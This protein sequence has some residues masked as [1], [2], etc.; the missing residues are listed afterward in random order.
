M[1]EEL[2]TLIEYRLKQADDSIKEAEV[3]LKEGMSL[4]SVMNRLYYAMFYAVLA[5]LQ[6]KQLGTSKHY[7]AISL[8][9]REFIK[10]GIFDKE[11]SKTL[12][13]SFE[14]RQKG[15][16]MEQ[17]EITKADID[18]ILPKTVAFINEIKQYILKNK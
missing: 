15:D 7:G 4:R 8:F 1:K 3:L 17:P 14:L 9:D 11:L 12:H 10:S 13:R 2:F 5:L 18:E 6:E 16:Y